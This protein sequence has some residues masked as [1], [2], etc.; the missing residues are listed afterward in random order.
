MQCVSPPRAL[1]PTPSRKREREP[2]APIW[3]ER[4]LPRRFGGRRGWSRQ[5]AGGGYCAGRRLAAVDSLAPHSGERVRVRGG[6][7]EDAVRFAAAR[8]LPNPLPQA[9]EGACRADLAG[10]G[11]GRAK[12]AGGALAV[13]GG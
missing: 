10:E 5:V 7:A 9:G 8:P 11:A 4:S 13:A 2:V 1:S 6:F 12:W 3:R